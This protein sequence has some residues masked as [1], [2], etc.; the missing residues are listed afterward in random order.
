MPHKEVISVLPLPAVY[1]PCEQE[2]HFPH[3]Y[4]L[5]NFHSAQNIVDGQQIY[6]ERI[7]RSINKLGEEA[8]F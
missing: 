7:N 5:D 8:I 6:A 3:S 1:T 4:P 2:Y